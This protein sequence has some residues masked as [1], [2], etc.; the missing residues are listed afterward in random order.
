MKKDLT[1]TTGKY[2]N[3]LTQLYD[4]QKKWNSSGLNLKQFS[5]S[6]GSFIIEDF[7]LI[8]FHISDTL[9]MIEEMNNSEIFNKF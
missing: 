8:D 3:Q 5:I 1:F 6:F 2:K 9:A 4:L 7:R